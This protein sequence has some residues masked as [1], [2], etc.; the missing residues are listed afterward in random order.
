MSEQEFQRFLCSNKGAVH[1]HDAPA[2]SL[3]H[4]YLLTCVQKILFFFA[5]HNKSLTF[6]E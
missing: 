3:W 2:L 5:K 1:R 6:A 4:R